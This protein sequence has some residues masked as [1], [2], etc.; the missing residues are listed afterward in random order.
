MARPYQEINVFSIQD[1][2]DQATAR[3]PWL[4]RWAVDGRQRSKA[5]RTQAE[6]DRYRARILLAAELGEV[7]DTATGEPESW[8]PAEQPLS[9]FEWACRWL[10]EQWPEWQPR[11]RRSATEA[12]ARFVVL[13]VHPHAADPP[14]GC[15]L[16][17]QR[18]L[19]PGGTADASPGA[20]Q[21]IERWSLPLDQLDLAFLAELDR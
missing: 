4:V 8:T 12:L 17:L 19:A 20:L 1:R 9:V 15:R 7:F 2:R 10:R 11:T 18:A 14:K 16:A 5:F 21:W 6:A 13:A 3:K